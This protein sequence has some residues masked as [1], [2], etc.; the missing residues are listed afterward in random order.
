MTDGNTG[1]T[2][3]Q[4]AIYNSTIN[5]NGI[6]IQTTKTDKTVTAARRASL[7]QRIAR[8]WDMVGVLA[9]MGSSAAYGVF[10]LAHLGL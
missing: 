9:L 10:A 2:T 5:S 8:R 7:L 6:A 3:M 4:Q 1:D